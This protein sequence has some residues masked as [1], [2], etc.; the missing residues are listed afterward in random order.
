L[1]PFTY[2]TTENYHENYRYLIWTIAKTDFKLRYQNSVL[3]YIWAILTPLLLFMVLNFVFS[4]IFS[5]RGGDDRLYSLGLI[6]GLILYTFFQDGTTSGMRSL[7]SKS[8]LVSKI[9]LSRWAIIMASTIHS[10]MI[11]SA[12]LIVIIIFLIWYRFLPT[13]DAVLLFFLLSCLLYVI[14]LSVS[15]IIAPLFVKFR[16][17]AM[18]WEVGL[19]IMFYASPIFYPLQML[20]EWIQQILLINPV[21]FIIHFTKESVF[22]HHFLHLWQLGLF[23]LSSAIFFIFSIWAYTKLI[24][25][26]AESL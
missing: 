25:N 15:M 18:I 16:D 21:A 17:I 14:I 19:R 11:F 3:G 2:K 8:S 6:V 4:S 7:Q 26:V 5:S 24:P 1:K 23:T 9:Y 12:N 13:F 20:P 10:A 22:H